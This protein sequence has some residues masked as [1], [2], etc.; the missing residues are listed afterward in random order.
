MR[1]NIPVPAARNVPIGIFKES[2][3]V[4]APNKKIT[5][6]PMISSLFNLPP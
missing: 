4:T 5:I 1:G 2:N 3:V 6:P